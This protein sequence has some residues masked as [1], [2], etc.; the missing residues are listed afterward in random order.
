M[1]VLK[2]FFQNNHVAGLKFNQ[3]TPKPEEE[4]SGRWPAVYLQKSLGLNSYCKH[5]EQGT[6]NETTAISKEN[7]K[8]H[9]KGNVDALDYMPQLQ[10]TF[11]YCGTLNIE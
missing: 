1:E 8:A 2:W 10:V 9:R 5:K 7:K 4:G 11:I 3:S 6:E